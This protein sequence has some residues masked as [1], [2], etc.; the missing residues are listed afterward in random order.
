M[1]ALAL[2]VNKDLNF[3]GQIELS[4]FMTALKYLGSDITNDEIW[5][6]ANKS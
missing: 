3:S 2:M 5:F 1:K 6:L 4:R